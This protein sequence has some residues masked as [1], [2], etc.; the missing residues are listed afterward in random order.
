MKRLTAVALAR[1]A[2][3]PSA[4]AKYE[5]GRDGVASAVTSCASLV[6]S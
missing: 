5:A 6:L 2:T 1:A 4:R 3:T